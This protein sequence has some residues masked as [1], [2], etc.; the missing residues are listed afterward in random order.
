M[1]GFQL[2][3]LC[4]VLLGNVAIAGEADPGFP[5]SVAPEGWQAQDQS[6]PHYPQQTFAPPRGQASRYRPMETHPA[7]PPQYGDYPTNQGGAPYT[8]PEYY[9]QQDYYPAY[10]TT[11]GSGNT[12]YY[13][14]NPGYDQG[15]AAP[16][17]Y[18]YPY[19]YEQAPDYGG[20]PAQPG[21]D[22]Q[23]G[24]QQGGYYPPQQPAPEAGY[25][26]SY[27]P[28]AYDYPA[29]EYPANGY[30]QQPATQGYPPSAATGWNTPREPEYAPPPSAPG[31]PA[32]PPANS[33]GGYASEDLKPGQQWPATTGQ[34]PSP[35][36]PT[37]GQAS[38]YMVNGEPAVFRPWS[39]PTTDTLTSQQNTSPASE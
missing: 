14:T 1:R 7:A 29:A 31:Y 6:R 9:P 35:A 22:Y 16:Q 12:Y 10:P 30:P 17:P 37:T 21:Y 32:A 34:P 33:D 38:G 4:L 26:E 15:Y 25:G 2:N 27:A 23:P 36:A 24:Y 20:Y 28:P 39:E 11:D 18:S 8:Y 3:A 19:V 13:P 5:Q